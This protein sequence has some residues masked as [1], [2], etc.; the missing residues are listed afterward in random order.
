MNRFPAVRFG[1]LGAGYIASRAMAPAVHA[2]DG[3]VVQAVAAR[4]VDRARSLEPLGHVYSDY[5]ALLA[6]PDVEAVYISL[7]NEVHLPWTLAALEAGKHVMCEKPLGLDVTEV[8]TMHSAASAAGLLLLEGYFYRWHPRMRRLTE[9]ASSGALGAV[10]RVD[11]EFSFD[12]GTEDRMT[13]NYRLDPSRGGGALYDVGVYP[14]SAAHALLGPSLTV[15]S[16][17]PSVGP[18]GV[19]LDTSASLSAP[20]GVAVE[21]RCGIDGRTEQHLVVEGSSGKLATGEGETFT[22]WHAPSSLAITSSS[23]EVH[24][25]RFDPVD[26]YQ[27]M[28]EAFSARVRGDDVWLVPA[29]DSIA[30]ASTLEAI[31]FKM[32]TAVGS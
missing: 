23:G 28:I 16:A 29:E 2:A 17:K 10:R 3:A 6:D 9:L 27:L 14:I 22:N 19:D 26:P 7:T 11:S 5:R 13:G 20:G 1:F 32:A 8:R 24:E 30:V 15:V 25:E 18:T 31:R 4:D 21:V 12:G